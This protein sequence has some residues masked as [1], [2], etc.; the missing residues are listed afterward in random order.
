MRRLCLRQIPRS[1]EEVYEFLCQ[2]FYWTYSE[3]ENEGWHDSL[4]HTVVIDD[5]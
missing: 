5:K 1:L 4:S 2:T 3:K